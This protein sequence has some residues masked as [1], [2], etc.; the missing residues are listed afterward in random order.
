MWK[1]NRLSVPHLI[2]A[3]NLD[4]YL[5]DVGQVINHY[6]NVSGEYERFR[7][8]RSGIDYYLAPLTHY[9]QTCRASTEFLHKLV[10][11]KPFMIARVLMKGGSYNE[12]IDRVKAYLKVEA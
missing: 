2:N 10:D 12:A 1:L 3:N 5:Y 8:W 9:V 7:D 6:N 4:N 11:A